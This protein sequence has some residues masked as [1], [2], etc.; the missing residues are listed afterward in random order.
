[1]IVS[2]DC[3]FKRIHMANEASLVIFEA[4]KDMGK[5][6]EWVMAQEGDLTILLEV[7]SPLAYAQKAYQ[8]LLGWYMYNSYFW[9]RLQ[10]VCDFCSIKL[11]VSPSNVWTRGWELGFRHKFYEVEITRNEL[12]EKSKHLKDLN[13]CESMI[14]SYNAMPSLWVKSSVYMDSINFGKGK[15]K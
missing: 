6:F 10:D 9:G 15:K 11:L 1:M 7:A 2:I 4:E 12:R 13:E 8:G 14:G 5:V 3:D